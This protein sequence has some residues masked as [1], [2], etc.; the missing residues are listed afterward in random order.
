MAT[1][2]ELCQDA[3][4][5]SD[6]GAPANLTSLADA[7]EYQ[8]QVTRFVADAWRMIQSLYETWGWMRREIEFDLRE[9]ISQYKWQ[10][11][12]NASGDLA[13]PATDV[14]FRDWI[15]N[16]PDEE[17]VWYLSS[18]ENN[19]VSATPLQQIDFDL[20]RRRRIQFREPN[21][22]V[23]FA[24]HPDK[25]LEFHQAPDQAY[26]IFGMHV[27]GVES[28]TREN[29]IPFGLDERYHRVIVWRAV[30]L[31]HGMD[32]ENEQFLF[33]ERNFQEQLDAVTKVYLP[34]ITVGGAL[35]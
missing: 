7:D 16:D 4:S 10:N 1:Y 2:L 31:L 23:A 3:L 18:P 22:P 6:T 9:N 11:L 24:I 27:R 8:S 33:A 21:Q 28:L 13:I 35:F 29:Q 14:G 19:Y 15:E 17:P 32:Q 25:T 34:N 20:M 26:R 30:M 5:F 12:R